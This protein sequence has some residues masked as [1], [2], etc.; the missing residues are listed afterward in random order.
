MPRPSW[1]TCANSAAFFCST[2]DV[3]VGVTCFT[4]LRRV[5]SVLSWNLSGR[6][7]NESHPLDAASPERR[8]EPYSDAMNPGVRSRAARPC[9]GWS[10]SRNRLRG[11]RRGGFSRL[12][13]HGGM[14]DTAARSPAL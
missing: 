5:R 13:L 11:D 2:T 3:H 9:L 6:I 4:K 14:H 12:T 1:L 10:K 8:F 7:P